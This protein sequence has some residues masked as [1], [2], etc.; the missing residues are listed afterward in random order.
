MFGKSM[1]HKT[2]RKVSGT[3]SKIAPKILHAL[4]KFLLT[5][6]VCTT[7]GQLTAPKETYSTQRLS[8]PTTYSKVSKETLRIAQ[9]QLDQMCIYLVYFTILYAYIDY[10]VIAVCCVYIDKK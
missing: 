4:L 8:I 10:L 1:H 5:V 2:D 9:L 7:R 6:G 3:K